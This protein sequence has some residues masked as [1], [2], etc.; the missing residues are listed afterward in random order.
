MEVLVDAFNPGTIC[1]RKCRNT[2]NVSWRGEAFDC[3]FNQ[4]LKMQ[5]RENDRGLHLWD[6]PPASLEN[7][8][9]MTGEKATAA[10]PE[11][12]PVAVGLWLKDKRC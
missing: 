8:E 12:G 2:I 4:M 6:P 9:I 7:R 10:Q 5:L 11:R 3:D 1:R